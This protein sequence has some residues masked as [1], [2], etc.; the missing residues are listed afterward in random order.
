MNSSSNGK[1]DTVVRIV[2]R[3]ASF[4]MPSLSLAACSAANLGAATELVA[5]SRNRVSNA[6]RA[7]AV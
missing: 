7:A 2:E 4:A 5:S 1:V 6:V 3:T